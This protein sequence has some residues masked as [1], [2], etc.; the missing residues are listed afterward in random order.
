M[1]GRVKTC[2]KKRWNCSVAAKFR[3]CDSLF[4][5]PHSS[6]LSYTSPTLLLQIL[7][8]T[9]VAG[10]GLDIADVTHVINFDMPNKIENYCHRIGRTARAGKSGIAITYVTD[11]DAE[12]LYDLKVYLEST[13]AA[14]PVELAK[15]QAAQAAAGTRDLNSGKLVG[16]R[17]RDQILYAK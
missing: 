11:Q 16:E 8:A 15:H 7:V 9:D 17:K 4:L 1:E 5:L 12:V 3:F 13:N 2:V 10:R 6:S 14:I